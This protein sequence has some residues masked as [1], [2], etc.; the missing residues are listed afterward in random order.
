MLRISLAGISLDH[1]SSV[2]LPVLSFV[3]PISASLESRRLASC[4]FDISSEKNATVFL[5]LHATFR[6][7]LSAKLVLPIPGRAARMIRS[8]RLRPVIIRSRSPIPVG[9]GFIL[10]SVSLLSAS[11]RSKVC[12]ITELIRSSPCFSLPCLMS[13]I[14]CSAESIRTDGASLPAVASSIIS[15]DAVISLRTLYF[16]AIIFA[17]SSALEIEGQ[18]LTRSIR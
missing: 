16:S 14:F 4:S 2:S 6:A 3:P 13:K 12:R 11:S 5:D 7:I 9:I 8:E 18:L 10:L 17:Y 1:S 15:R